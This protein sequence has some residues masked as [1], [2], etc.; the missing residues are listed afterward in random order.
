MLKGQILTSREGLVK[1]RQGSS[2]VG[3]VRVPQEE[4]RKSKLLASMSERCKQCAH[5]GCEHTHDGIY[6]RTKRSIKSKPGLHSGR[7]PTPTRTRPRG[8]SSSTMT[9]KTADGTR[10]RC[11]P[12]EG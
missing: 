4:S 8:Q 10:L 5:I 12:H 9:A 11:I 1:E 2:G 3:P 6:G 7:P